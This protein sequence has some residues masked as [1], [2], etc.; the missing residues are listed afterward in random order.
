MIHMAFCVALFSILNHQLGIH[1]PFCRKFGCHHS[2]V[3]PIFAIIHVQFPTLQFNLH[4]TEIFEL[5]PIDKERLVR[6]Y[7]AS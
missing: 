4:K 6:V 5:C 1:L 3:P 7:M 2:C